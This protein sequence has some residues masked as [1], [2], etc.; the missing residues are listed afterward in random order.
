[1]LLKQGHTQKQDGLRDQIKAAP[2]CKC[3]K[4]YTRFV[5]VFPLWEPNKLFI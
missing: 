2:E 1:M 5:V 3:K 4:L